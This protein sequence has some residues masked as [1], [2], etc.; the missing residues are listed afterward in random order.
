LLILFGEMSHVLLQG[1]DLLR[2]GTQYRLRAPNGWDN[3]VRPQVLDYSVGESV[4]L[5]SIRSTWWS[6]LHPQIRIE[7]RA[8]RR[9]VPI[10]LPQPIVICWL[11]IKT[12]ISKFNSRNNKLRKKMFKWTYHEVLIAVVDKMLHPFLAVFTLQSVS[13]K[14]SIRLGSRPKV[15]ACKKKNVAS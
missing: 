9:I 11:K 14:S 13:T 6:C 4:H 2:L 8:G 3:T 10:S 12:K 7:I 5:I 15:V 1:H